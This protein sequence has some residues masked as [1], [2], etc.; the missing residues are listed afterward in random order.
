MPV[1]VLSPNTD[2][3]IIG[4]GIVYIKG[5]AD[6][7][8]VDVG[9]VPEF[10]V[11]PNIE[12]LD[13]FS[14]RAGT[15]SKDKSVIQT[16]SMT[17]RLVLEEFTPRNLGLAL[18][19]VPNTADVNGITIPVFQ[20]NAITVAVKL[21]GTNDIGPKWTYEFPEVDFKPS[22]AIALIS[23]EWGQLEVEG[24]ILYQSGSDSFGTATGDFAET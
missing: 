11:T 6:P 3:Y 24:E 8:Y 19:G 15:R 21:V 13:H 16:K 5:E 20:E 23:E 2:N 14:S 1:S 9:N 12:S 18:L 7:D 22:A 17:L 4:K 10:E